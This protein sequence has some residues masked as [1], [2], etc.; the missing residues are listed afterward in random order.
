VFS[1][2]VRF[3]RLPPGKAR[4]RRRMVEISESAASR[5]RGGLASCNE[6][7]GTKDTAAGLALC[8][9]IAGFATGPTSAQERAC[10]TSQPTAGGTVLSYGSRA[11]RV[12]LWPDGVL[13]AGILPDGGSYALVNPDGSI[14]AKLGWWRQHGQLSIRGMR[15]DSSAPPLRADVRCCYAAP[16][17]QASALIFPT[18]GCWRIVGRAGSARLAFVVRVVRI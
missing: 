15:I 16:G 14:R 11:L 5:E 12:G 17:L 7:V 18:T 9:A 10:P 13:R 4:L 3:V 2:Q 8:L 1:L 6:S